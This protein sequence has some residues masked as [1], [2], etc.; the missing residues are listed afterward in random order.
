MDMNGLPGW[1]APLTLRWDRVLFGT[2][3]VRCDVSLE[4]DPDT[5]H[6]L[7][8]RCDVKLRPVIQGHAGTPRRRVGVGRSG[9]H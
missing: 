6:D 9:R 8:L 7:R 2:L 3:S 4:R 5:P 1:L